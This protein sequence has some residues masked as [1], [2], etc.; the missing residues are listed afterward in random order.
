MS[1]NIQH[2]TNISI[3]KIS[4][5][6]QYKYKETHIL[7]GKTV[8]QSIVSIIEFPFEVFNQERGN[9]KSKNIDL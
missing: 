5:S 6:G 4:K 1:S 8:P 3:V 9:N 2:Y 7:H